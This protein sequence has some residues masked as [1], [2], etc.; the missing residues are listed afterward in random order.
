MDDASIAG[1]AEEVNAFA[2]LPPLAASL[3]RR[4]SK[5]VHRGAAGRELLSALA[6][7]NTS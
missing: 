3:L 1:G 5:D 2:A 6:E 7:N 4:L